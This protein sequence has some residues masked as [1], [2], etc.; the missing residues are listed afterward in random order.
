M[1]PKREGDV[2]LLARGNW[3]AVI[4]RS[5]KDTVR[6]EYIVECVGRILKYELHQLCSDSS[7]SMLLSNNPDDIMNFKWENLIRES[8]L[9]KLL[10]RCT[11]TPTQK[12]STTAIIGVIITI[13]AK[14]RRQQ[15]SLFQKII[16]VL[17]YSGH[18][19]KRVSILHMHVQ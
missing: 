14:H 8:V 9:L 3:K 17:L 1:T 5:L 10:Y 13:L 4:S 6:R 19:A 7:S 18:S 16:S 11:E 2:K 12:D 15:A